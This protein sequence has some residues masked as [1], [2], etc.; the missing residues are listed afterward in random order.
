[1][2]LTSVAATAFYASLNAFIL[3]WLTGATGRARGRYKV[4]IG[5][6]GQPYL[7]RVMRGHANAIEAIPVFLVMLALAALLGAPL[8]AIHGLGIP[9]T[10]GRVLHAWHFIQEDAPR[11]QRGAGFGL[12]FLAFLLLALGLLAHSVMLMAA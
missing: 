1:M 11:W 3:L 12:S 9:F 6:G 2:I 4:S 10:I 8:M 5:D 7:I